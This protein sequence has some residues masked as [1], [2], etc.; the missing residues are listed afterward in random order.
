MRERPTKVFVVSNMSST[1]E[2]SL[3]VV[4]R[5]FSILGEFLYQEG[6]TGFVLGLELLV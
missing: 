5:S 1:M 2:D 3:S 4:V 6:E